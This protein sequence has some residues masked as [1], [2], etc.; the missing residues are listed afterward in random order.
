MRIDA[1]SGIVLFQTVGEVRY[2]EWV[3]EVRAA[4]AQNGEG[5]AR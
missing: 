3:G 5:E 1:E 4:L 2:E